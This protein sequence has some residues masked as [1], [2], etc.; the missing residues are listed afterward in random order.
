M[1]MFISPTY[2]YWQVI[3]LLCHYVASVNQAL[4]INFANH[5]SPILTVETYEKDLCDGLF[6]DCLFWAAYTGTLFILNY[7]CSSNF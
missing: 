3:M 5:L 2:T 1:M 4:S 6:I 7:F